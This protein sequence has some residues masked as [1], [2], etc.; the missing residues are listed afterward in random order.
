MGVNAMTSQADADNLCQLIGEIRRDS[1]AEQ[2]DDSF[3][4][5]A[6]E[7]WMAAAGAS[8]SIAEWERL[9]PEAQRPWIV[10]AQAVRKAE[11]E[12]RR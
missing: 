4:R 12:L 5:L 11:R 9:K 8:E 7:A 6:R 2:L 3:G 10:T 1:T